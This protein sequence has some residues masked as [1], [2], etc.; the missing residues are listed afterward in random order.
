MRKIQLLVYCCVVSSLT[1][2][3]V[4]HLHPENPHYFQY[5][6][7]PLMLVTSGEHYG[8]V[9]NSAFDYET[10]LNTL[11]K[12]GFNLTRTFAGSYCEGSY[13]DFAPTLKATDDDNQNSLAPR[14][15]KFIAPWARSSE[16]GY[17][18]GGNKF[19]LDKWDENYFKRLKDFC[20]MAAKKNIIVELVFFSANYGPA[21]W[22]NSPLNAKNNINDVETVAYNETH[23]LK[24]EKLIA[25]QKALVRKIVTELNGFDNIYFEICNEPY[26]I[27]GIPEVEATIKEQQ[28]L[29]EIDEWQQVISNEIKEGEKTLPKK[30]LIA[31]NYA[32]TY[33]KI[34]K[35][36]ENVSILNFHYAY[37]P[38]TVTDNYALNK[39]ISFDETA[40]GQNAPDRRREAWAFML[41]GGAVYDNLD[42]S[43]THDDAT[44]LGH[45]I[46]GKRQSGKEVR[47]QLAVLIKTISSFNFIKSKPIDSS[48]R[49]DLPSAIAFHGLMIDGKDYLIYFIKNKPVQSA[50]WAMNLPPGNYQMKWIDPIDGKLIRQESFVHTGNKKEIKIPSFADDLLLRITVAKK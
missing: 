22:L 26:W 33:Y 45:N 27:K 42:W 41:E 49:S 35:I 30:H 32:N 5:K 2:S 23:L 44:G 17:T 13:L 47:D 6:G 11:Q 4:I 31:Q 7:K 28:F 48:Y 38:K 15:G 24:N 36:D 20:T 40:E 29:P 43:F 34:E 50:Q 21:T 3:Q 10:Y 18:N 46:I 8:A 19:D 9:L 25:R 14:Y 16:P 39:P 1:F 12:Y 37:P